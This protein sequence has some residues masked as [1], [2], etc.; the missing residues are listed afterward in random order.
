MQE[1]VKTVKAGVKDN[2]LNVFKMQTVNTFS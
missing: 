1:A 2:P